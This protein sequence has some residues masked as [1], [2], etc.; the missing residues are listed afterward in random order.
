MR[1]IVPDSEETGST[2]E[3]VRNHVVI[4]HLAR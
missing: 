2:L 1:R 3:A 4:I